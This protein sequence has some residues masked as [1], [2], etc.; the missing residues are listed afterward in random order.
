[1]FN[2][3]Q[4]R[5]HIPHQESQQTFTNPSF[6]VSILSV[7]ARRHRPNR[8]TK[9]V[10]RIYE[11]TKMKSKHQKEL[12]TAAGALDLANF[13]GASAPSDA[14]AAVAEHVN[15]SVVPIFVESE[16]AGRSLNGGDLPDGGFFGDTRR[17]KMQVVVA[18]P[19]TDL[20]VVEKTAD[21][22]RPIGFGEADEDN[23]GGWELAVGSPLDPNHAHTV[24]SGI[25]SAE[26]E[27]GVGLSRHE[28]I[29]ST[30]AAISRDNSGDALL[31]LR[32]KLNELGAIAQTSSEGESDSG[33]L[34]FSL[35]D[36]NEGVARQCELPEDVQGFVITDMVSDRPADRT[37]LKA[38]DLM[39]NL[40]RESVTSVGDIQGIIDGAGPGDKI[41]FYILRGDAHLFVACEIPEN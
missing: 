12:S 25:I 32:G 21:G 18:D 40:D 34:G 35:A 9:M 8:N 29:T 11:E 39:L 6:F 30:D 17:I 26:G 22:L 38:G 5:R 33:N 23:V 37:G 27:S 13:S 7:I 36:M 24:T 10:E 20:A 16:V 4:I 3:K 14:F 31:Q 1:L 41:L 2:N 28:E 15:P 19:Q